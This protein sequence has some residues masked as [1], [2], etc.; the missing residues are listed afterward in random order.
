MCLKAFYQ[1]IILDIDKQS[2]IITENH[3]N[4]FNK[5]TNCMYFITK[6]NASAPD[7]QKSQ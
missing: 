4:V 6:T 1:Q 2:Q 7:T 5:V 3:T